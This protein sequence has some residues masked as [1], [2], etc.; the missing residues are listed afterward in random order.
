MVAPDW[1]VPPGIHGQRIF[2]RTTGMIRQ[3]LREAGVMALAF[4]HVAIGTSRQ[5]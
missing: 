3:R 1:A 4:P 2:L 5:P